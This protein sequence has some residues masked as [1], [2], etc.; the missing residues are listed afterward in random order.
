M[1]A[2][3][4]IRV[5]Q[6]SH[7]E[8]DKDRTHTHVVLTPG[9]LV[10]HY[11]IVKRIAAGGMGEVYLAE[12]T[13]LGRR[14]ALKFLPPSLASDLEV[15]ARFTREAQ[16]AAKLDHPNIVTVHEVGDHNGR[17]FFAM[18][19]IDGPTLHHYCHEEPL[20]IA[21]AMDMVVQIC[22]GLER[23]HR[24][25]IVHRDIKAANII[26]DSD[27]R[28]RI[29]DFG[30]AVV[31]GSEALTKAGTTLGT[32][33]YMSPEQAKGHQIDHRSDLFSLGSVLYELI[34]GRTP[35]RRDS[36]AATLNAILND[37]AEPMLRYRSGV[38][39]GLQQ[40]VGKL[41]QKE[42]EARY[43]SAADAAADLRREIRQLERAKAPHATAASPSGPRTGSSPVR[44]LLLSGAPVVIIIALLLVLKPWKVNVELSDEAVASDNRLAVMYFDNL[45]DPSDSVRLGEVVTNL[46][47]TDLSE[48]DH[49][50]VVSSQRMYDILKRLGREESRTI[51]RETATQVANQAGARWML[52]G[53]ILQME[54]VVVITTQIIDVKS[55]QVEASQRSST[56]EQ[57]DIFAQVDRLSAEIRQDLAIPDLSSE[58]DSRQ[59][60]EITT[61]SPEAY[62]FYLEGIDYSRRIYPARAVESFRKAI[63]LDSTFAL[64]YFQLAQLVR[65]DSEGD[66]L[67]RKAVKYSHNA[68]KH[69]RLMILSMSDY[70]AGRIDDAEATLQQLIAAYPDDKEAYEALANLY[71][72][73]RGDTE[74]GI[75]YLEEALKT[76][77]QDKLLYNQIAYLYKELR[78]YDK[79]IELLDRYV[80]IAPSEANPY[81]SKGEMYA[82]AG[83]FDSAIALYRRALERDPGFVSATQSLA[84]LYGFVGDYRQADSCAQ[85]CSQSKYEDARLRGRLLLSYS[86]QYQGKISEALRILDDGLAADRLEGANDFLNAVK[87]AFKGMLYHTIGREELALE[88]FETGRRVRLQ[89]LPDSPFPFTSEYAIALFRVGRESQAI[90]LL[91][92]AEPR[93][94]K[95]KDRLSLAMLYQARG[96]IELLKGNP[97]KAISYLQKAVDAEFQVSRPRSEYFLAIC[98]LEN[99]QPTEAIPLL[100]R[101]T[102]Q[103]ESYNMNLPTE[104]VEALHYLGLAYE[105]TGQPKKATGQYEAFLTRWNDGDSG[106]PHVDEARSKL[107]TLRQ[108]P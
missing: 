104:Q 95:I 78:Q 24:D 60:S 66:E 70:F 65:D 58:A 100:R 20:P 39:D 92:D 59:L 47:I 45:V 33:A 21:K 41:L 76:D 101:Y 38:P 90:D 94:L 19:Y 22:D 44:K 80:E 77:P 57:E 87:Y 11:R 10:S 97:P 40:I 15:R 4:P 3:I 18:Q 79:A 106:L 16:A 99:G 55:G 83:Q 53:T 34:A 31:R 64:A 71:A 81:D 35:F 62:R 37:E 28:P 36:D 8:N 102:T 49:L 5:G 105:R 88:A 30:V 7:H 98:Y 29:V 108:Q 43:Q 52:T 93:L 46:L 73:S 54:P 75:A 26:I 32:V 56:E 51:D 89:T 107:A 6:M 2:A 9:T 27:L 42:P 63:D 13:T 96:R 14:V 72:R 68:S 84:I 25:G 12:D 67:I 82:A 17:P 61:E 103:L 85:I 86:P 1:V 50:R 74:K 91:D 23:A 48:V 69:D